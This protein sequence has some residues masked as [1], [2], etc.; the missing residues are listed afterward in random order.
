MQRSIS[1]FSHAPASL[2][3]SLQVDLVFV[4]CTGGLA[5]EPAEAL[6]VRKGRERDALFLSLPPPAPTSPLPVPSL[7]SLSLPARPRPTTKDGTLVVTTHRVLWVDASA[8]PAPGSSVS[9]SLDAVARAELRATRL[10][11][12]QKARL[13]LSADPATGALLPASSFRASAGGAR[14]VKV[15]VDPHRAGAGI[16]AAV[17]AS[18][19]GRAWEK[20]GGGGWRGAAP[21]TAAAPAAPAPPA[22]PLDPA[23][24][25]AITAL[26]FSVNAASHALLACPG[27]D[28]QAAVLWLLEREGD[29]S[30]EAPVSAAEVGAA[31]AALARPSGGGPGAAA[32]S[33]SAAERAPSSAGTAGVGGLLRAEAAR[34]AADG[35]AVEGAFTDL[36]ALMAAASDMVGLA[37]RVRAAVAAGADAVSPPAHGGKRGGADDDGA[38][39]LAA[40]EADL[41]ALGLASPVT[42]SNTAPSLF[43]TALARQL[44]DFLAPHVAAAGGVLPLPDAFCLFNRARGGELAAPGDVLAAARALEA[45]RAPLRLRTF[46]SGVLAVEALSQTDAAVCARLRDLAGAGGGEAAGRQG[47]AAHTPALVSSEHVPGLGPALTPSSVAGVLGVPLAVAGAHLATAEAAGVL[48]RDAGPAGVRWF[49]NFFADAQAKCAPSVN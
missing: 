48:C 27:G 24:L 1:S 31:V 2:S 18:L 14:E 32:A 28:P 39:V 26:G 7:M 40:F 17:R 13:H 15:V 19:A 25:A 29:A 36:R 16:E 41:A 42:R 4:G 43:T 12:T 30:L 8:A 37:A 5:G 33:V 45:V 47:A 34:A 6:E 46:P 23:S 49:R 38:A 11:S 3:L 22:D 44:S 35:A 10:W 21:S 20:G 9:I